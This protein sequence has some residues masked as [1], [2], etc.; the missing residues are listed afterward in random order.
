VLR[1]LLCGSENIADAVAASF[2]RRENLSRMAQRKLGKL[3][4]GLCV[5]CGRS[6]WQPSWPEGKTTKG[7]D[8]RPQ[9]VRR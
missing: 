1:K 3:R 5:E 7:A 8:D 9:S 6:A 2:G 4:T